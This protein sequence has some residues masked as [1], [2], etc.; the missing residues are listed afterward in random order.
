V[1]RRP[2]A[3]LS[4]CERLITLAASCSRATATSR[5]SSAVAERRHPRE[6][7]DPRD[8]ENLGLEDVADAGDDA[9][10]Q[11][12]VADRVAA[13]RA[14]PADDLQSIERLATWTWRAARIG[15]QIRTERSHLPVT[16]QRPRRQQLG[17]RHVEADRDGVARADQHAHLA[18]R[19]LP[20]GAGRIDVPAAVHP[21]VGAKNEI[22]GETR[23]AD[24]C[25]ALKPTRS[26]VRRSGDRRRHASGRDRPIRTA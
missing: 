5:S 14:E 13:S 16:R 23:S 25:R 8:E 15:E 4:V 20:A 3:G 9:L 17:D 18:R 22:A 12:G 2:I 26:C 24:A 21:H 11:Q 1:V 6:R 19:P 10:I 7:I